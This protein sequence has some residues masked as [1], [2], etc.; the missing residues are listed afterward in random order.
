[1]KWKRFQQ[2]NHTSEAGFTYVEVL[3]AT[4]IL[5]VALLGIGTTL[6]RS[7]EIA[8]V[9]ERQRTA[10]ALAQSKLEELLGSTDPASLTNAGDFDDTYRQYHWQSE[11]SGPDDNGLYRIAV[12][13]FWNQ[14]GTERQENLVTY[15]TFRTATTQS[16]NPTEIEGSRGNEN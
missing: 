16:T 11:A 14:T 2:L 12:S 15:A 6:S 13:V 8:G 1:M 10:V 7:V 5:T 9:Q 3:I 4:V